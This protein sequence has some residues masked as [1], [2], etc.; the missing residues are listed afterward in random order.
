MTIKITREVAAKVLSVVDAGLVKGLGEAGPGK[1]CVEAAVCYALGL[2][3]GDDPQCVAP[4]LRS[5]KIRLNDSNWSSEKARANGLR[6]L[7]LV[8]LGSAG[9]LDEGE[10][11]RR[12][13]D[14]AIRK[15]VPSA[16]RVAASV[17]KDPKHQASLMAAAER[18]E[19]EGTRQA[20]L[21]AY[22]AAAAA[23]AACDAASKKE[24]ATTRD[25][26]LAGYAED[27]VKILIDMKV[28]GVQWLDLAAA[29]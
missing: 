24:R 16:L 29:S 6:R 17:H 3:H 20:A 15:A 7:A 23:Y 12:I 8:Q 11:I 9:H 13:V 4:A 22:A 26:A 14:L 1:G 5:F 18:C 19:K 2:P 28:P 21:A 25:K 27:V 10:F